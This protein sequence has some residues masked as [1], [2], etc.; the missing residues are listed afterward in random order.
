MLAAP[1]ERPAAKVRTSALGHR[2]S[3]EPLLRAGS[4]PHLERAAARHWHCSRASGT[5]GILAKELSGRAEVGRT[6][7]LCE[8]RLR[9]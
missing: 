4:V 2:P 8:Y 3:E 6:K 9:C 1:A 7:G 5:T